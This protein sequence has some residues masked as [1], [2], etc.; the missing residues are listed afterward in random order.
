MHCS[1]RNPLYSAAVH[2]H[3]YKLHIYMAGC[4]VLCISIVSAG[5]RAT[6]L[7]VTTGDN[8]GPVASLMGHC[9]STTTHS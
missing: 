4:I 1:Y 3:A 7:L 5:L 6:A 8:Y 2:R 9:A